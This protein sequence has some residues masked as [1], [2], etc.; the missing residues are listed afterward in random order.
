MV[1]LL[2]CIELKLVAS[3]I[4]QASRKPIAAVIIAKITPRTGFYLDAIFEFQ[5]CILQTY[6]F[7]PPR[8]HCLQKVFHPNIDYT[9]GAVCLNILRLEWSPVLSIQAVLLG[10]L[11]ILLEPSAIEPLE[12]VP[13]QLLS[14][15]P[16][17]F[18]QIVQMTIRGASFADNVYDSLL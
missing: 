15:D 7:E 18:H 12:Q 9:V 3:P 14:D 2:D 6:P 17:Q 11:N 4:I 1:D 13:A 16:S 5:I 8:V 10:I